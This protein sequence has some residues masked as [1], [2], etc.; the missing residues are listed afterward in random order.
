MLV[1]LVASH[2]PWRV[3]FKS[4][5]KDGEQIVNVFHCLDTAELSPDLLDA[6][7]LAD[8]VYSWV[9]TEYRNLLTSQDT[10]DEIKVTSAVGVGDV[11]TQHVRPVGLPGT[12]AGVDDKLPRELCVW[13]KASTNTPLRSA[14]GGMFL[15]PPRSAS[16]LASGQLWATGVGGYLSTIVQP[17]LTKMLA[18]HDKALGTGHISY[19]I[20]SVTRRAKG[21]GDYYF[22]VSSFSA[23]ARPHIQ[24]R[25]FSAP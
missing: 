24:R 3:A 21:Y 13:A 6:S 20:Y 12:Y 11:P 17:F 18:G 16:L 25:R 2:Q 22:D 23:A 1:S 10:W 5:G 14:R 7:N 19:I 9:G 4:T 8:A 15:P